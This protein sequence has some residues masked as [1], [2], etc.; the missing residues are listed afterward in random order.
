MKL[1]RAHATRVTPCGSTP[2]AQ[3]VGDSEEKKEDVFQETAA[4]P[5]WICKDDRRD[6]VEFLGTSLPFYYGYRFLDL[7]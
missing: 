6:A 3:K 5:W 7:L 4:A 2:S 1:L